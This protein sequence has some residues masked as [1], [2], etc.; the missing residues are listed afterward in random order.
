MKFDINYKLSKKEFNRGLRFPKEFS[1]DFA[2]FIG[3][4]FGDGHLQIKPRRYYAVSYS[5]NI[6]DKQYS[7]YVKD[8]FYRFLTLI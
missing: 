1:K 2:E 8:I 6:R 4:H 3:I 5:F 7:F